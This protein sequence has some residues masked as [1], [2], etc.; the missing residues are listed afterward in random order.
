[1]ILPSAFRCRSLECGPLRCRFTMLE[2]KNTAP[3]ASSLPQSSLDGPVVAVPPIPA[4]A[5]T[6]IGSQ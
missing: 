3:Q 6:E 4:G 2:H 5:V 1:M